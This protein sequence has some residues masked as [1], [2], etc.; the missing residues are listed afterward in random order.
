M[1]Q[2]LTL[3]SNKQ[4]AKPK[5]AK[6]G[7]PEYSLIESIHAS[8]KY[9]SGEQHSAHTFEVSLDITVHER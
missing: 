7:A 6:K 9:I 8:E 2:V 4:G 1:R 3:K 5:H